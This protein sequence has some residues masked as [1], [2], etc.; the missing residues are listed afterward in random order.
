MRARFNIEY[1]GNKLG[2]LTVE[3]YSLVPVV[4]YNRVID[5]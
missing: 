3:S 4:F 1:E 5:T 2:S